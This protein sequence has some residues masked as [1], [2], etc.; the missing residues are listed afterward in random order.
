LTGWQEQT[1]RRVDV[2]QRGGGSSVGKDNS[3]T[4]P[5]AGEAEVDHEP[6]PQRPPD[7]GCL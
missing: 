3:D 7:N 4:Q 5:A 2:F 1:E 6:G